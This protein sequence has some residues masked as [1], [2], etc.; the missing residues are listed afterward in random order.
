[1]TGSYDQVFFDEMDKSNL[2]S[3]RA[4]V[5][6][7]LDLVQP[8]SVVDIG[9][10]RG[11]WLKAFI[12]HGIEDVVGYD[13][14]YV[15]REKLVFPQARFRATDLEKPIAFDRSFDLAVCLEVAEHLP[16]SVA[17]MLIETLTT[18]ARIVL[19]SAAIPL[20]GGSRHV[21]EQWPEYWEKKF[22]AH[23]Y[24]PVDALRRHLWGN[25]LISFFYQ[26]NI[27]LY[28]HRDSLPQYPKLL[29]EI[30]SGHDKALAL[31]HP[32][33]F[34]YY[35]ERWRL[36]VP[37]LG[38]LPPSILHLGKNLL[39]SV[40]YMP[41]AQLVRYIISGLTAAATN[42]VTLYTLVEFGGFYYLHASAISLGAALMV[43]FLLHKFFTFR[44]RDI[45][46]THVQFALYLCVVGV[47]FFMNLAIMWF[48]VE[49]LRI[50]YLIAAILAGVVIAGTNFFAYRII[51]FRRR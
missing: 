42:L 15:E 48:S 31:I 25:S 19:F 44:E 41:I 4:V 32:F 24:V 47:N 38:V 11:L 14:D 33:L 23:G 37:F 1:M 22:A 16:A 18:A 5:P 46:Q 45:S 29:E 50:P 17:D 6:L 7:V 12:E 27:L 3:A 10:G 2:V 8:K 43:S 20:Q 26:Q 35:S 30:R 13:G 21:N 49:F 9:C 39:K 51:V 36:V 34:T 28:I 40:F